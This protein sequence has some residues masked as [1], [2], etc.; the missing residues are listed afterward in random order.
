MAPPPQNRL[1]FTKTAL[2]GLPVPDAGRRYYHDERTPGLVLSV[3]ASGCRSFM[4]YR[5]LEG[6]PVRVTLGRFPPL[7][8]EQARRLAQ[9]T[10]ARLVEGVNPIAE[11]RAAKARA[12]TLGEVLDDYL[13]AR[14]L[15]P[16]TV[17]MYRWLVED[18]AGAF[19]D[20]KAR[21][22]VSI[23][24]DQVER[25]H[26]QLIERGPGIANLAGTVLSAL[27]KFAARYE[28]NGKPLIADNPV[29]RLSS[30]RA[31]CELPRRQ[32]CIPFTKLGDWWRAT[33]PLDS[34]PRDLLRLILLTGLRKREASTLRWEHV[35]L[36]A[37]T[38]HV[39]ETKNHRPL[40]LPL[41][42][43]LEA[44]LAGRP[45]RDRS[46]HVFPSP[47]GEGSYSAV[48]E[49]CH[50]VADAAG[51][52]RMVHDLRRTFITV[53]ESLDIPGYTLKALVNHQTGA[54]VTQGYLQISVERL[55]DPMQRISDFILKAVGA[56]PSAAVTNI[57]ATDRLRPI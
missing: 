29:K 49:A 35:D 7:T 39:P 38:L 52:P 3:S 16:K 5:K 51:T 6:R 17:E 32:G 54:D 10:L 24:R 2:L 57:A 41:S 55:R 12:I 15:R 50:K 27:F 28:H 11:R 53:A 56:K 22:L 33:E 36:T 23:T 19:A 43:D 1:P 20:W 13:A 44:L 31:W 46:P 9:A 45:D 30:T 47:T 37:R 26:R 25:R 18:E 48:L 21:P 4:V 40:T 8:V 34:T 42:T 14:P